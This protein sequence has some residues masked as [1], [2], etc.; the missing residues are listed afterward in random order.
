[1][2]LI[3]F[4]SVINVV[5]VLRRASCCCGP[6]PRKVTYGNDL[7]NYFKGLLHI[8][9]FV[10]CFVRLSMGNA[11]LKHDKSCCIAVVGHENAIENATQNAV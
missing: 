6:A 5:Q 2:A 8:A 7:L 10:S 11:A 9:F 3:D 4:I 1:M